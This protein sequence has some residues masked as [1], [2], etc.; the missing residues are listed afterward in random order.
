VR[1]WLDAGI[2]VSAG[3][4]TPA[5]IYDPEHPFIGLFM[6][7]DNLSKVGQLVSGQ[8]ISRRELLEI[9]T[10][11]SAYAMKREHEFGTLAENMLADFIVVDT[12]LLDCEPQELHD[13]KVLATYL[14]GELVY[15][16]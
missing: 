14:G 11:N 12:D 8:A 5:A 2:V 1:Q 15:E 13:A 7:S 6:L 9:Y 3:S 16:R 4:N 10:R